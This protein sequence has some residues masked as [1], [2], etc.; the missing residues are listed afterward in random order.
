MTRPL[1]LLALAAVVGVG[2]AGSATR[3]SSERVTAPADASPAPSLVTR[4]VRDSLPP[5]STTGGVTAATPPSPQVALGEKLFV[6]YNCGDCHG[7]GG[8]GAMAPS[9]Q[10]NRWHYGGTQDEVFRSIAEGRPGGMPTWG[11]II[12]GPEMIALAAYVRSL[13]EGKD[14]TTENFTGQ[15]VERSGR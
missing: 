12:P 8:A 5:Q 7:A 2:A 15:T 14:L 6:S 11:A 3:A 13:G 9:L 10:D 4:D 1:S